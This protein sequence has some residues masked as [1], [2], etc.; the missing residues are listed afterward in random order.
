LPRLRAFVGSS[1]DSEQVPK[2]APQPVPSTHAAKI[3]PKFESFGFVVSRPIGQNALPIRY[4]RMKHSFSDKTVETAG[5]F[6]LLAS[7]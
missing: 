1:T 5:G 2:T 7:W 6:N 4:S 3:D